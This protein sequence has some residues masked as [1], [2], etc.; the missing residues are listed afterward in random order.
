MEIMMEKL[1][2]K[3]ELLPK[4]VFMYLLEESY[5]LLQKNVMQEKFMEHLHH[6]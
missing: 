6:F 5:K 1:L 4:G 2:K 3:D